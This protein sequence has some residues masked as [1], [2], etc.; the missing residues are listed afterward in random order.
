MLALLAIALAASA[1]AGPVLRWE[2]PDGK[3]LVGQPVDLSVMLDDTLTVRTIELTVR[4]DPD[5]VATLE[6]GPGALFDD[7]DVYAGFEQESPTTW[8]AYC[9]VL[10]ADSWAVGPGELLRWTV[11]PLAEGHSPVVTVD[12]G[13]RPP[14][15]GDYPDASLPHDDLDVGD[16]TAA[17]PIPA[18]TPRLHVH[19]N[20]FNPRTTITI[21]AVRG[22]TARLEVLDLRGRMVAAPWTGDLEVGRVVVPW[23]A[24]DR[25]G[26]PLASGTYLVRLSGADIGGAVARITLLR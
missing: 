24:V 9:V 18:A 23:S 22:G 19:P 17:A 10:G 2:R 13:L 25:H 15:G 20:P 4:Y 11:E 12:L 16:V 1:A 6:G 14:G 8:T 5:V 3:L 7:L 26:R 21:E